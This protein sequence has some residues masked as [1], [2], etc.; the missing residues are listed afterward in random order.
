MRDA[1]P[2]RAGRRGQGGYRGHVCPATAGGQAGGP[3][4]SRVAVALQ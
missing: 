3:H 2:A 1:T 4:S